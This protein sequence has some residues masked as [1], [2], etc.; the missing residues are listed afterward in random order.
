MITTTAVQFQTSVGK[1]W[2]NDDTARRTIRLSARSVGTGLIGIQV[3][4][5]LSHDSRSY[6]ALLKRTQ[7]KP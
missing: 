3:A 5:Q 1:M 7:T 6:V 4:Q 2:A